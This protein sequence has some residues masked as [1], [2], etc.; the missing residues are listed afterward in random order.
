MNRKGF[1]LFTDERITKVSLSIVILGAII[2]FSTPFL[3]TYLK[4]LGLTAANEIGDAIGGTVGP[5]INLISVLLTFLA[6]YVQYKANERQTN[7]ITNQKKSLEYKYLQESL[8]TLKEE[9]RSLTYTKEGVTYR[10]SEAI[11][12]FMLDALNNQDKQSEEDIL[13]PLYFQMAYVL[14]LFE[15][16]INEIEASKI[17]EKEKYQ[18]FCNIE[19]LF[20]ASLA[21]ILRANEIA[22]KNKKVRSFKSYV[23][24]KII[25]PAKKVKI[26]LREILDRH[27]ESEKDLFTAQ[28]AKIKGYN[29]VKTSRFVNGRGVIVF[30]KD[31]EEY[32]ASNPQEPVT[33]EAFDKYF[34]KDEQVDKLLVNEPIRLMVRLDFLERVTLTIAHNGLLYTA[35]VERQKAETYMNIDLAE[36]RVDKNLWR[37]DF[38]GKYVYDRV[39][40]EK[41]MDTFVKISKH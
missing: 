39:Q 21:F 18:M 6:F 4:P 20:E 13:E 31:F 28:V 30:F 27:K 11:W 5:V 38:V 19:G 24:L 41:F 25:I 2:A 7:E 9:I 3:L 22:A 14:T 15:P 17:E 37:D 23:R 40:R 33:K 12:Y 34:S 10:Y 36:F 8:D 1:T 26:D 16:L 29:F 35:D 32:M